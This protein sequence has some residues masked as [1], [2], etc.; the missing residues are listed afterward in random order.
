MIEL[1]TLGLLDLRYADGRE[2][3]SVL[4]Q[5]KRLALL[6]YLALGVPGRFAR[7]DTLLAMFWPESSDERARGAF[8]QAVLYLRRSLGAGVLVNRA[9]DELGIAD[10]TIRCD[11]A[12]LRAALDS[13]AAETALSLYRGD[14]LDGLFVADA[15]EFERWLGAERATLKAQTAAAAWTLADDAAS[16]GEY[17]AALEWARRAVELLPLDESGV[18]RRMALLAS[19][20]DRAGAVSAY[21]EFARRLAAELEMEPAA[22]TRALVEDVRRYETDADLSRDTVAATPAPGPAPP[23]AA[24]QPVAAGQPVAAEQPVA[25]GPYVAGPQPAGAGQTAVRSGTTVRIAVTGAVLVLALTGLAYLGLPR[26][27]GA[28]LEP[29]RVVVMPFENRTGDSEFASV[30]NMAADWIVQGLTG[31]GA[32]Q[33]VPVTAVLVSRPHLARSAD[34]ATEPDPGPV[35]RETGAGTAVSG[36]YYRQGDSLHFQARII[37]VATAQVIAAIGPVG[38]AVGAPL[39]GID[40]LRARVLAALA[41]LSDER[42][43]HVRVAQAPPSYDAYHAYVSGFESFVRHDVAGALRHFERAIDADSTFM[44]AAV[45]AAIMH[46]NLGRWAASDSIVRRVEESRDDLGPME[47]ATLDMVRAWLRGDDNAAYEASVLQAKLAPGS[48]GNYQV[49]EQARRLN[50]P[51]E[52]IRVLT[53]MGAERGELRG[54]IPYWRELTAAHHMLGNHRTELNAARRA[55]D[56]YPAR[57]GPL[58]FEVSALAALGRVAEVDRRIEERLATASEEPPSAGALMATAAREFR[59]HGAT[60]AARRLFERSLEW[61]RAQSPGGPIADPRPGIGVALYEL[62][63]WDDAREAF[64]VLAGEVPENIA[65]QGY[66]GVIAVR[67]GD[68]A[69]AERV[70]AWMRDLEQPYLV[71]RNTL[72]RARIAALSGESDRAVDL[73]RDALAQGLAYDTYLHTDVD[74]QPLRHHPRFLEL[75]RPKG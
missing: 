16:A 26:S 63:H 40:Q 43:T 55:R 66:L 42:D 18:R 37:D 5:P 48:I 74:L 58:L 23:V 56:L 51:R 17:P 38:S 53:E 4:A 27:A 7:R 73:L 10:G 67:Q 52:A 61:Y 39:D 41:P 36:S 15:P 19:T 54:W 59:A 49:A 34:G 60:D 28:P 22:A 9:E 11:A 62:G 20:G 24:E 29:R 47:L 32:L 45:S 57:P 35:A 6:V 68:R 71:G 8:R 75:M 12:E 69:E 13:G 21:E 30:A 46:A 50:R 2:I 65:F 3:R 70:D 14:L 72:W 1:R 64:S 33:V 25:A 44:M 31:R